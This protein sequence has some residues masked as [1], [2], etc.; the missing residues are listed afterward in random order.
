MVGSTDLSVKMIVVTRCDDCLRISQERCRK[1]RSSVPPKTDPD[2]CLLFLR[3]SL[4][5]SAHARPHLLRSAR[6]KP[7]R[8][9][10]KQPGHL[11]SRP[12]RFPHHYDKHRLSCPRCSTLIMET[13]PLLDLSGSQSNL[14]AA[15]GSLS[16][17]RS[18]R[19]TDPGMNCL[20]GCG[21]LIDD[22]HS[23]AFHGD[24]EEQ[25]G[26]FQREP[27]QPWE[28]GYPGRSPA[29]SAIPPTSRAP[30]KASLHLYRIA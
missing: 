16:S 3:M 21:M 5:P 26:E 13:G 27:T 28:S 24:A 15:I 6:R 22:Y 18:V 10:A 1:P 30:Y 14:P 23:G 2:L 25:Y 17:S 4:L 12:G 8:S 20:G 11:E 9:E 19:K 29:C 7:D